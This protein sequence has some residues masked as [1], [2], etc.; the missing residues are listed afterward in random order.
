MRNPTSLDTLAAALAYAI[1]VE[2]PKESAAANPDL[3]KYI[4][5]TFGEKGVDRILMKW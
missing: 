4:D 2:A 1:K 3:V 5:D